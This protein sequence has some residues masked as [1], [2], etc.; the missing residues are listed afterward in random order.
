MLRAMLVLAMLLAGAA[1]AQTIPA[2]GSDEDESTT[3]RT[4][5]LLI[6][7]DGGAVTDQDFHGRFQLITFGYTYCPDIC[8]TTLLEIAEVL[9]L[10]GDN[11]SGLQ[12][13]F[14]TVDPERD[15][16]KA[17]AVY[18][19]FFDPRILGLGGSPALIQRAARNFR[20]R[21]EKAPDTTGASESY[22]VDHSAGL[23]LVGKDGGFIKKFPYGTAPAQIASEI[24]S[25]MNV[26]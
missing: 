16:A 2:Y 10:L 9:R 23:Y 26:R 8:P 6:G 13:I 25:L 1:Q 7:P 21:Y 20:V 14:V 5:Y 15:S 18:T 17:L 12:A 3:V 19:A 22:A 24:Q 11:A 4:R